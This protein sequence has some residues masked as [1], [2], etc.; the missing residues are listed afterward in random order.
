MVQIHSVP[1][2]DLNIIMRRTSSG[3]LQTD[4]WKKSSE[5]VYEK[6]LKQTSGAVIS[7]VYYENLRHVIDELG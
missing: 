7:Q 5:S 4:I 1:P 2:K 3:K 6:V